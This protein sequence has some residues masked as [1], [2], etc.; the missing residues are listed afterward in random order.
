MYLH[1]CR[2]I[3]DPTMKLGLAW[4]LRTSECPKSVAQS[5]PITFGLM[6]KDV[7][8]KMKGPRTIHWDTVTRWL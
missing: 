1:M 7:G 4:R 6:L 8:P 2:Y 3:L 5:E